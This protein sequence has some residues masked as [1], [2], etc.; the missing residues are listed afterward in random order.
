VN[1]KLILACDL[2]LSCPA[3]AVI[4]IDVTKKTLRLVHVSHVKTNSKKS[5]GFRL[6]QISSHLQA[7][8]EK[9]PITDAVIEKGFNKFATATAQLQRVVG[10]VIV[11]LYRKGIDFYSE[12]SPTTV[13]KAIT[14]D[15]KAS[16]EELAK[17]L[18]KWV[19]YDDYKTNDESD[20]VGVGIAYAKQ[21]GWI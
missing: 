21:K 7:I 11:T 13:K 17:H 12:L 2:S 14:G 5:L 4:E 6:F 20:S 18:Y 8:L 15:G 3:F 1:K 10:V 16:K 19:K 9:F